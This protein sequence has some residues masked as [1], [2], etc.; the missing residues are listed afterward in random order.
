MLGLPSVPAM[1]RHGGGTGEWSFTREG[2][3]TNQ[4]N[5]VL[6]IQSSTHPL[7][8]RGLP[9]SGISPGCPTRITS[10]T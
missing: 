3:N 6:D 10:T 7:L 2:G 8:L 4:D 9:G 1:R 5:R